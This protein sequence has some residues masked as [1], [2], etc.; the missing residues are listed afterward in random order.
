MAQRTAKKILPTMKIAVKSDDDVVYQE[1]DA[2]IVSL[3]DVDTKFGDKTVMTLSNKKLNEFNVFVNNV[4]MT[5]LI[6]AYGDDD[7]EWI[8][9]PVK[10]LKEVDSK[11]NKEMI[12]ITPIKA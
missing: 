9:K 6:T 4:S 11:F 2:N 10:L 7:N 5:M 8:G 12:V 1:C 3:T